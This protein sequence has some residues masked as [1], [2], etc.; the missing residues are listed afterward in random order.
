MDPN[1]CKDPCMVDPLSCGCGSEP[2]QMDPTDPNG[3]GTS[4]GDTTCWPEPEPCNEMSC[5]DDPWEPQY[6]PGDFGC[7]DDGGGMGPAEFGK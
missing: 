1:T 7:G 2:G 6:P 5:P 4:D 3:M